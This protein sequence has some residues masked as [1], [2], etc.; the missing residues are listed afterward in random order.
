MKLLR[1]TWSVVAAGAAA[2]GYP[3]ALAA[4]LPDFTELVERNAPAVVNISDGRVNPPAFP[5]GAATQ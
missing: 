2:A 4:S 3:P 5:R 1:K